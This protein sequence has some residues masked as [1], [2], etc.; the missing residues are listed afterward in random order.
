MIGWND[1]PGSTSCVENKQLLPGTLQSH[2]SRKIDRV[3]FTRRLTKQ[4]IDYLK[5]TTSGQHVDTAVLDANCESINTRRSAV[6]RVCGYILICT[7]PATVSRS[8]VPL[9]VFV[10]RFAPNALHCCVTWR[11]QRFVVYL[12]PCY[13]CIIGHLLY[14]SCTEDSVTLY[15]K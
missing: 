11:W 12:L 10:C 14:H 7:R 1:A 13:D 4:S 3:P 15:N 2:D 5:R 9:S 6:C 8:T